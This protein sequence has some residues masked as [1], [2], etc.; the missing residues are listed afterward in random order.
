MTIIILATLFASL[1]DYV[2]VSV[3]RK[4]CKLLHE[5]HIILQSYCTYNQDQIGLFICKTALCLQYTKMLHRSDLNA[6]EDKNNTQ[7]V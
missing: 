4:T 3:E 1:T 5:S 7:V 6:L 2:E